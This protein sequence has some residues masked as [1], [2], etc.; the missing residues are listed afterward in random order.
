[1]KGIYMQTKEKQRLIIGADY[2]PFSK[3]GCSY[4]RSFLDGG[5]KDLSQFKMFLMMSSDVH[6]NFLNGSTYVENRLVAA[7]RKGG[8]GG[9]D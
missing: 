5:S 2:K 4:S 7:E 3:S 6:V 9:N 1:M 8:G